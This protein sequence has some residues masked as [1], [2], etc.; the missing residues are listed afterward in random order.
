MEFTF[1]INDLSVEVV[2][3]KKDGKY[4]YTGKDKEAVEV[5]IKEISSNTLSLLINGV[6]HRVY[7]AS[8]G[9]KYYGYYH[10]RHF[11]IQKSSDEKDQV[12]S[13]EERS[14]EEMLI[15]KARVM[16]PY[17]PTTVICLAFSTRVSLT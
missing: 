10:G 2:L 5:D 7:L 1:L 16:L 9:D 17:L 11:V 6:S 4:Y 3:E 15:I 13:G 8:E 12:Q 14:L